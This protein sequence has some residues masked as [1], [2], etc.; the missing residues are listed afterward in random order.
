MECYVDDMI[1]KS[2]FRDHA[3]DLIEC[4]ETLRKNNMRIN[5]R[6]CTFGISSR[7]FLGYMVSARVIE[8]NPKKK[9]VVV[10]MKAPTA[11]WDIKKLTRRLATLRRF[12]SRSTEKA[13]PFLRC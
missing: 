13:L 3:V 8:V 6:K 4:F 2:L 7:K 9:Q 5:L 1:V 12:V 11:I 10:N